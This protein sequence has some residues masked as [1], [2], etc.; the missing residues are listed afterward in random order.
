MLGKVH[1][2]LA[3]AAPLGKS[4]VGLWDAEQGREVRPVSQ[5]LE[6]WPTLEKLLR[7]PRNRRNQCR[8]LG[9]HA[10]HA[11]ISCSRYVVGYFDHTGARAGYRGH[12]MEKMAGYGGQT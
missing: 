2:A 8:F 9:V 11:R 10:V 12:A 7:M 3:A 1:S 4:L 6:L 5:N